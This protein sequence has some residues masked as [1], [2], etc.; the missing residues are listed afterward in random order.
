MRKNVI[1][2][3]FYGQTS[4]KLVNENKILEQEIKE[5]AHVLDA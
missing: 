3:N 4:F 5:E 1:S 2:P